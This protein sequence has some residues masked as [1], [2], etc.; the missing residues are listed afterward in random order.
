MCTFEGL[1]S[2]FE[3]DFAAIMCAANTIIITKESQKKKETNTTHCTS[4][5]LVVFIVLTCTVGQT[6]TGSPKTRSAGQVRMSPQQNKV[7]QNTGKVRKSTIATKRS[8]NGKSTGKRIATKPVP[9]VDVAS[10]DVASNDVDST[11]EVEEVDNNREER[12][13]KTKVSSN[14]EVDDVLEQPMRKKIMLLRK[15]AVKRKKRP[16]KA[17]K[18]VR[19]P[20][21][22]KSSSSYED[23]TD[24]SDDDDGKKFQAASFKSLLLQPQ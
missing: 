3:W 2:L 13:Q 17:R 23:E 19:A 10:N 15:F 12:R 21:F 7:G 1:H 18:P 5:S 8:L 14:V 4:T 20:E 22:H 9:K 6:M 24:P 16:G 11:D